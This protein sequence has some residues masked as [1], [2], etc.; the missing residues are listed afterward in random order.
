MY[1]NNLLGLRCL[2]LLKSRSNK[3]YALSIKCQFELDNNLF[4][5]EH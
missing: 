5:Q 2:K 3:I 1:V 4:K